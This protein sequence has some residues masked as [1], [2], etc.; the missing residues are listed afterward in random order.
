M[1]SSPAIADGIIFVGSEDQ[2][3]YALDAFLGSLLWSYQTEGMVVSSPAIS[4]GIAY[5]G[6]Y[7]HLVYAIGEFVKSPETYVVS[8]LSSG[9]P[10]EINWSVT[11]NS[12][13]K[14]T[15]SKL[16]S[17]QAENG[18]YTFSID[19]PSNYKVS[20]ISGT[21]I[22][23]SADVN[24]TVEFVVVSDFSWIILLLFLVLVF[25]SV[26]AVF[27]LYKRKH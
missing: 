22:V 1:D 16:I 25:V 10:E 4:H 5:V 11:F 27:L 3:L 19:S 9:L 12:Q 26:I 14:S 20:P 15:T 7:D 24:Q 21:L 13:T 6:S 23:N 2:N 17:F 18:N 8:F